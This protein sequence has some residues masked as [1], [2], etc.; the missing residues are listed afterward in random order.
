MLSVLH[1]FLLGGRI[2]ALQLAEQR[3]KEQVWVLD[4]YL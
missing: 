3:P 1:M 2:K 4:L